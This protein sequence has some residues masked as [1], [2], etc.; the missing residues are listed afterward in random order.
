MAE[1]IILF[2]GNGTETMVSCASAQHFSQLL[3]NGRCW[4]WSEKDSVSEI[5]RTQLLAHENVFL[6]P[7][8]PKNPKQSWDHIEGALDSI[9]RSASCVLL[10]VHGGDGESGWL[11]ERLEKRK[12]F[13]TASGSKASAIALDKVASKKMASAK[14]VLIAQD[15]AFK[16][17]DPQIHQNLRNLQKEYKSIVIKPSSEGSSSNLAF[18]HSQTELDTWIKSH[19]SSSIHWLAE[20][21]LKGREFTIGVIMHR[22]CLTVLPASE[23]ILERNATFDYKGKYLGVGNR[24]I[25]PADLSPTDMARVQEVVLKAHLAIG[26]Y[27]YTRSEVILTDRGVYYLETNTLPG[28]TKASFIPQQLAAAG[29]ANIDFINEQ[30]RLATLRY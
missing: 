30:L 18:I 21:M 4:H 1:T 23:V 25:T 16:M 10:S 22:G 12:I 2:G 27:G 20:E 8:A 7:F 13:F 15:F 24:E 11:Q 3:P 5:D 14:G 17:N 29:I 9:D 6:S 28:F 26:C 19:E